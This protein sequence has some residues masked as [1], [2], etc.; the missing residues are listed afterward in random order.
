MSSGIE[1]F[2]FEQLFEAFQL[3]VKTKSGMQFHSFKGNKYTKDEEGYK[4]ELYN[5][6]R[7]ALAFEAWKPRDVGA[8]RIASQTVQAIELPANNCF[9]WDLRHG[10]E[11]RLHQSILEAA[12]EGKNRQEVESTLYDIF[13]SDL[14]EASFTRA[15]GTFGK[16]YPLIAYLFFL[17]DCSRYVPVEPKTFD[18]VLPMFGAEFKTARQCSWKNYSD[19]I[20]LIKELREMLAS[21]LKVEVTLLDAHSFAWMVNGLPKSDGVFGRLKEYNNLSAKDRE[22]IIRARIGQGR[23]RQ[24]TLDY[25]KTCAVTGCSE[26]RLLEA[27]HIKPWS[28]GAAQECLSFYNGLLLTPNLHRCLDEGYITFS[29]AGE[30]L[31][32]QRLS[33]AD[34]KALGLEK[35]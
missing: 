5:L 33:P 31:I 13:W 6:G 27:A 7:K 22:A 24:A 11:G 12:N 18:L 3:F 17:K 35:T 26:Q 8:G 9:V 28:A 19:F 16:K 23:F 21:K 34:C 29:E 32:S 25:W 15:V 1:P 30:M 4:E 20:G 2:H 10:S 14:D